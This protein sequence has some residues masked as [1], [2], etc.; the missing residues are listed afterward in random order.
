MKT[1]IISI[2]IIL[3][4]NFQLFAQYPINPYIQTN[5]EYDVYILTLR[6]ILSNPSDPDYDTPIIP[7][8]R[9]TPYLEDLSAIYDN[10]GS[11]P[12]IDFIFNSLDIH[13]NQ[14]YDAVYSSSNYPIEFKK[15]II[16]ADASDPWITDF[17]NTGV[18]GINALDSLMSTYQFT[19]VDSNNYGSSTYYFQIETSYNYMNLNALVEDFTSIPEINN[20]EVNY[21]DLSLRFNYIGIPYT[22]QKQEFGMTL[23]APAE[24]SNIIV[25]GNNYRF[26]VYGSDC[27]SG[28]TI[29]ET[30]TISVDSNYN[31]LSNEDYLF[32]TMAIYPNPAS[33]IVNIH[34]NNNYESIIVVIYD[35]LGKP[36]LKKDAETSID[37]SSLKSGI[38]L[39]K[40]K[41]GQKQEIKK[42]VIE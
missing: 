36:V 14:E 16:T 37:V 13:A 8:S 31:V 28:C 15:M 33:S 10:S 40:L 34:S 24:V 42:L 41:Q 2:I 38:Y 30:R 20:V 26:K 23:T 22:V 4:A 25:D 27:L 9:L 11:N 5:Y 32:E 19:L 7:T 1:K 39:L 12:E 18:S 17:I 6:E 29:V 35:I 3:V 21:P